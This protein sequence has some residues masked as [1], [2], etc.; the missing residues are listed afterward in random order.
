MPGPTIR[1]MPHKLKESLFGI[2]QADLKD[3]AFLD[4]FAGTGSVGIEALSRGAR[5]VVFIEESHRAVK[6]I[7]ANLAKCEAQEQAI[8]VPKEFNRG[9]IRMAKEEV[10]FDLIFLDPPYRLLDDRNPL[11]VIKKRDILGSGGFI[12]LRHHHKARFEPKYYEAYRV[13][14]IGD[15][16]LSFFR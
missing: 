6:V 8:I 1:A 15:D 12:V 10:K 3:S 4:G 5:L 14:S 2:I 7:Q 13:V 11:K 9:V 16:T